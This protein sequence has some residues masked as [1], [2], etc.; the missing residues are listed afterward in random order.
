MAEAKRPGG[1]YVVGGMKVDAEGRP[2]GGSGRRSRQA[3]E[4]SGETR[5]G[6]TMSPDPRTGQVGAPST[7]GA[8]LDA[9]VRAATEA[10][11]TAPKGSEMAS[12]A[13]PAGK[14]PLHEKVAEGEKGPGK[15]AVDASRERGD[16]GTD[17]E[18]LG[19][20]A[21]DEG[22]DDEGDGEEGGESEGGDEGGDEPEDYESWNKDDLMAEVADREITVKGSGA[23]GNVLVEDLRKALKKD[24]KKKA[25]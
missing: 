16:E 22:G 25:Q 18:E 10:G 3:S 14:R 20:D 15:D 12:M 23:N 24:D 9:K 11:R 21:T 1:E 5:P 6:G 8:T 17:A 19:T 7:E 2:I 13:Q 4:T